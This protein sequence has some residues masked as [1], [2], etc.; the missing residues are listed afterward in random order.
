MRARWQPGVHVLGA[1]EVKHFG[2][3]DL[4]TGPWRPVAPTGATF[5]PYAHRADSRGQHSPNG[6]WLIE[7]IVLE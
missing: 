3:L 5:R 4:T 6:Q 7:S 2:R 1:E